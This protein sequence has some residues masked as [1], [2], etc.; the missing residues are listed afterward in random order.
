PRI[1]RQQVLEPLRRRHRRAVA[2]IETADQ[3]LVLG[4]VLQHGVHLLL[5]LRR[6]LARRVDADQLLVG[7]QR[8]AGD[9]LIAVRLLHP[10]RQAVGDLELHVRRLLAGGETVEEVAVLG[11][12]LH[13]V[14]GAALEVI[15]V[16]GEQQRLAADGRVGLHLEGVDEVGPGALVLLA[17]QLLLALRQRLLGREAQDGICGSAAAAAA[18]EGQA[19]DGEQ[20]QGSFH[21][22][23]GR[24]RSRSSD[25]IASGSPAAK[26]AEPTTQT[27]T[28]AA[29]TRAMLSRSIPPSIS[30]SKGVPLI[31]PSR[32]SR[33]ALSRAPGRNAWPEKPGLTDMTRTKSSRGRASTSSSTG[34]AGF[35]A[36]P[37]PAPARR[38]RSSRRSRCGAASQWMATRAA[39]ASR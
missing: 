17:H 1:R 25:I 12:R 30:I 5:G 6:V 10:L 8:L 37:A 32:F 19:G 14:G 38:M 24:A 39:P 2:Q 20:Q 35:T 36:T 16:G 21:T 31:S 33:R 7:L 4:E 29:T 15:G 26:I 11:F 3:E 23:S 27:S 18:R 22:V 13:E 34:V 9:V 28:P